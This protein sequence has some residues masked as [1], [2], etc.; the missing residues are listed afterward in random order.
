VK[1]TGEQKDGAFQV[2]KIDQIAETCH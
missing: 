1:V 2:D